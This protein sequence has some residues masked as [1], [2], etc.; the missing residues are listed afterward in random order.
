MAGQLKAAGTL[1]LPSD[2]YSVLTEASRN[3]HEEAWSPV[4]GF[5]P[6]A[7]RDLNVQ[8]W[9]TEHNHPFRSA[10]RRDRR[11]SWMLITSKGM[12]S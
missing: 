8:Q 3:L 7:I 12:V 6:L 9:V 5:E 11:W 1:T 4:A 2:P 10:S